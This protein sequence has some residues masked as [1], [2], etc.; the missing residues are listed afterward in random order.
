MNFPIMHYSERINAIAR[1]HASLCHISAPARAFLL[2]LVDPGYALTDTELVNLA[3]EKLNN[4]LNLE[5]ITK[6]L[7]T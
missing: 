2:G 6:R 5:R 4:A 1:L 7:T 3:T